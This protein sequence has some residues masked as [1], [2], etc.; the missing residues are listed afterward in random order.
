M[1]SPFPE[2]LAGHDQAGDDPDINGCLS[3]YLVAE[4]VADLLDPPA[5]E[6]DP[7]Q[8]EYQYAV[9]Q[10]G[11]SGAT[12]QRD[13]EQH[14]V[15]LALERIVEANT[16]LSGVGFE[17]GGLASAHAIHNGLTAVEETH[18]YYH[19]EKVAF[20]VLVGLQLTDVPPEE[21][22][23][24]F[25]F[26]EELGLP[27]TLADIGLGNVDR[28]RLMLVA[29]KACAPGSS[30]HHEAGEMTPQKVVDALLAANMIGKQREG[31]PSVERRD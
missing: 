11:E 26:C 7:I 12:Q 17:S 2:R 8:S 22:A 29:E 23:T 19:G 30:I 5:D 4:K 18:A 24:V 27:N 6:G 21:S 10:C 15:T 3:G 31:T 25:S 9:R 28:N 1:G 13:A 16:L 20:G 14:K